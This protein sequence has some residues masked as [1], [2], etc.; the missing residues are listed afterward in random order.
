MTAPEGAQAVGTGG[1]EDQPAAAPPTG[2]GTRWLDE[3]EMQA[4]LHVLRLV[5]LLPGSLDRQL[6]RD[7]GLTHVSYMIL[8]T[9]SDAPGTAMRMTEL[10]RETATSQSRLSHAVS[11]LEQRGWVA[12]RP[13][14]QDR[15]GQVAA[16]TDAGRRLLEQTAPGHVAQVRATVLDPL[17]PSEVHQLSALLAKIVTPLETDDARADG[18]V[19]P[20][21][22]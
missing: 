22:P 5:M 21:A 15:R 3:T 18:A 9:L 8:A 7:A 14:P 20:V 4:W 19:P 6:R 16:L 13:C 2:A 17:T 1:G 10:A 11:A 12:R